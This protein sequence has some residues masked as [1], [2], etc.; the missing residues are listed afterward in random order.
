MENDGLEAHTIALEEFSHNFNE[1]H[2]AIILGNEKSA[3]I[4]AFLARNHGA[5]AMGAPGTLEKPQAGD[6]EDFRGKIEEQAKLYAA[7]HELYI[8]E[9]DFESAIVGEKEIRAAVALLGLNH[10]VAEER[11]KTII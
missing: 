8:K 9:A 1:K 4:Q 11:V 7:T 6:I 2:D 10:D 3:I 5:I